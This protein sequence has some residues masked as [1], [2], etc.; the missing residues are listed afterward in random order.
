MT[1]S[2]IRTGFNPSLGFNIEEFI[3]RS[4]DSTLT[5]AEI[6]TLAPFLRKTRFSHCFTI[7]NITSL[8]ARVEVFPNIKIFNGRVNEAFFRK[9]TKLNP[10]EDDVL[11]LELYTAAKKY[12]CLKYTI[13]KNMNLKAELVKAESEELVAIKLEMERLIN[14][15]KLQEEQLN[16]KNAEIHTLVKELD[17]AD[18][19]IDNLF[20]FFI[21]FQ[22]GAREV[23]HVKSEELMHCTKFKNILKS[24]AVLNNYYNGESN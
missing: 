12:A 19:E 22:E 24:E 4:N 16:N 20:D 14:L 1:I 7:S 18:K 8:E 2:K 15:N 21:K 17:N 11:R 23:F 3:S 9:G 10:T 5:L 6:D 13:I